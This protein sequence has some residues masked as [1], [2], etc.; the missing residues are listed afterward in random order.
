[1]SCRTTPAGSLA[2]T[3]AVAL[4]DLYD[5]Q[6][7]SLYHRLRR[8][9]VRTG[10]PPVHVT[11]Y[12][13]AIRQLSTHIHTQVP[14]E[15][16]R[17]RLT[18]REVAARNA[19]AATPDADRYA[20]AL[21]LITAQRAQRA[22]DLELN[23]Y[24]ATHNIAVEQARDRYAAHYRHA[25]RAR[26]HNTPTLNDPFPNDPGTRYALNTLRTDTTSSIHCPNCGQFTAQPADSTR[27]HTCPGFPPVTS[28]PVTS[29]TTTRPRAQE[30]TPTETDLPPL[31]DIHPV[32]MDEFQDLYDKTLT[33]IRD[34]EPFPYLRPLEGEE[35]LATALLGNPDTPTGTT[36]G[37][38]LEMDFPD[39]PWP[40]Q[41][42]F[43]LAQTL[44]DY[45]LSDYNEVLGWHH[46]GD[47]D[48]RRP[49]GTYRHTPRGWVC[50]FDRT[51]DD[52]EGDRGV[53]VKS[54]ILT[55]TPETWDSIH[56]VCEAARDLGAQP[57]RRTGLHVNIGAHGFHG[58]DPAPLT[59]LL[60]LA[61]VYDDVLTR[62]SH[63]P[64]AGPRHRGRSYCQYVS[65]PP[66]G[67]AS[68]TDA[69][70][71]AGHYQAFN[72]THLPSNGRP[73]APHSRIEMR[74][75]DASLDPGRI[76]TQISLTLGLAAA[77]RR[78]ANVTLPAEPAGSHRLEFGTQRLTGAEWEASTERFRHL[79][80]LLRGTGLNT[81]THDMQFMRLFASSRWQTG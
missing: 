80:A 9:Y 53:E 81:R 79:H 65:V 49:G 48:E 58:E 42:R 63:N 74:L 76:Q 45:G 16:R 78:N 51:V 37:V 31:E 35:G 54:Q 12:E 7:T 46:I 29:T 60:T 15:N 72:L 18:A 6:C 5:G 59:R 2:T 30:P 77:A 52:V 26:A 47:S 25:S 17:A 55:D 11:N 61:S 62:M 70:I 39:A 32:S 20:T 43:D 33:S 41:P 19:A 3:A 1:M 75:F 50:E 68:V 36:F 38:E 67:F 10:M 44:H 34:G 28:T 14:T 13:N 73:A 66:S 22:I 69:Q 23:R 57:T 24:A 56:R 71:R 64:D 4:T 8:E 27:A 21:M 40:Y